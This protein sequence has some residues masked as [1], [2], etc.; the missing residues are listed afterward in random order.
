MMDS[1]I[2][3]VCVLNV[4]LDARNVQLVMFALVVLMRIYFR[5]NFAIPDV[6]MDS[7]FRRQVAKRAMLLALRAMI[8]VP[9]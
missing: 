6:L 4:Q 2:I 8:L 9:A 7:I 1:L 3:Q 5:I